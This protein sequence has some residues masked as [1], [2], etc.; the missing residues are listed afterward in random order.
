[1]QSGIRAWTQYRGYDAQVASQLVDFNPAVPPGK[2]FGFEDLRAE[3]LRGNPVMLILQNPGALSRNL[4]GMP[5][6][7]PNIHAMLAYHFVVTDNGD[8]LVQFRT[9]WGSGEANESWSTWG[10]QV[11]AAQLTLRGV[12]VFRP[13]PKIT[14]I[15]RANGK[16]TVRWD[17]PSSTL[18]DGVNQIDVPAQLYSLQRSASLAGEFVSVGDPTA[19]NELTLED[20][21]AGQLFFR[22]K[23]THPAY[24][25]IS[26]R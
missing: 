9:S 14:A 20:P 24:D 19:S 4:P 11:W 7:N 18:W 23:L 6:G 12:I 25:G 15:E 2:G 21:G 26:T 13:L 1:V 5:R 8:Q 10:P 16:V 22:V 17:G 3:I